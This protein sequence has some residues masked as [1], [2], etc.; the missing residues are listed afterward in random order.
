MSNDTQDRRAHGLGMLSVI[1]SAR[2]IHDVCT[3]TVPVSRTSIRRNVWCS[4][5]VRVTSNR[6]SHSKQSAAQMERIFRLS[7]CVIHKHIL[8]SN[9]YTYMWCAAEYALRIIIVA[10][11]GRFACVYSV[12]LRSEGERPSAAN[13]GEMK[14]EKRQCQHHCSHFHG[15]ICADSSY[16]STAPPTIQKMIAGAEFIHA[17]IHHQRKCS[18][19]L[20]IIMYMMH[21]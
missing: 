3:E 11:R 19:W 13:N 4:A 7:L 6:I 5:A 17:V 16:L 8:V 18:M 15:R 20:S 12:A 9:K 10:N 1:T 2:F 14:I 21:A